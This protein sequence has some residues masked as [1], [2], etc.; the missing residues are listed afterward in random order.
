MTKEA[1][2]RIKKDFKKYQT[3]ASYSNDVDRDVYIHI[4]NNLQGIL[5][6]RRYK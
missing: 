2:S 6:N 5:E 3:L 1:E 4:A